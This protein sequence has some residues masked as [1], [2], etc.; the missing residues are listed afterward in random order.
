MPLSESGSLY[1]GRGTSQAVNN[2][3]LNQAL[4]ATPAD[5]NM[6]LRE[7][8]MTGYDGTAFHY[9]VYR[10]LQRLLQMDGN[11]DVAY[12]VPNELTTM[13]Q[14]M[15]INEDLINSQTKELDPRNWVRPSARSTVSR[16][17][18]ADDTR[19]AFSRRWP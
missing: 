7:D 5:N 8:G 11:L 19:L 9:S 1:I 13:W 17:S 15:L 3:T 6:Y 16:P 4:A 10:V 2:R 14:T 12:D 18:F